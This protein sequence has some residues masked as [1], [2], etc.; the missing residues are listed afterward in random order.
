MAS[1]RPVVAT[2]IPECRLH[3][4]RFD[5]VES[6]TQFVEAIQRILAAGSDD[7]RAALRHSFAVANSCRRVAERILG[8]IEAGI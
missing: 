6:A 7:G 1:G 2:A 5:V 4:V 3:A 8:M